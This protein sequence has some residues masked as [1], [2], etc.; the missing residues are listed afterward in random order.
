MNFH[1]NQ[2]ILSKITVSSAND[3]QVFLF[4]VIFD[5]VYGK[6]IKK[7][8]NFFLGSSPLNGLL[9]RTPI[10]CTWLVHPPGTSTNHV[11][12]TCLIFCFALMAIYTLNSSDLH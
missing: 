6:T 4:V 5:H 3:L 7:I 8:C 10:G 1:A 9:E 12:D 11:F 2:P